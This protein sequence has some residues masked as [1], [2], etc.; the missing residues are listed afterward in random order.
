MQ[1]EVLLRQV[2]QSIDDSCRVAVATVISC[3]G[4]TP[5]HPGAK[6]AV[7]LASD[8]VV[9]QFGTIGGGRVEHEVVG[10]LVDVATRGVG[11]SVTHHLVR[12]LA[13]CCGGSMTLA[14]SFANPAYVLL[15][16]IAADVQARRGG[17]LATS[18]DGSGW[19][20]LSMKQS[21]RATQRMEPPHGA[22]QI[23]TF[24]NGTL[25]ELLGCQ[26]RA[27]VFGLGHVTRALGPLLGDVGF[28]VVVCDD[29]ETLSDEETP[30]WATD[31]VTSFEV[32]DVERQ[33]GPFA[34]TDYL[35]VVTRD[36]AVDQ[37]IIES[38]VLRQEPGFIGLIGSRG[39]VARFANRLA[40]KGLISGSDDP[41]WQR[42]V[43]PIGLDIGA[44]TPSEIAV[45]IAAQLVSHRRTG[46]LLAGHWH[47]G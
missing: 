6:M 20:W 5:R 15:Q 27:V 47:R 9:A 3:S 19:T 1:P 12:D 37:R 32:A 30:A 18:A 44:E 41:R 28:D 7:A 11:R 36:H 33:I 40:A 35:L 21:E 2:V 29:G 45:A 4:S 43:A 42:I 46:A 38:L 23:N 26:P 13:M 22:T 16:T 14:L 17:M 31:Y 39:K 24:E 8:G 25:V 34:A 10:A